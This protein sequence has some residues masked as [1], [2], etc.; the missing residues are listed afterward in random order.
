MGAL[1]FDQNTPPQIIDFDP[2]I[3][4]SVSQGEEITFWISAID[5]DGD[6]LRYRWYH[7]GEVVGEDSTVTIQFTQTGRDTVIG[8]VLDGWGG[9]VDSVVWDDIAV[10]VTVMPN[11]PIPKDLSLGQAYPNPFNATTVIPFRVANNGLVTITVF[12]IL[13]R[14]VAEL[15]N[16]QAL[17]GEYRLQWSAEDLPS[18]IYFVGLSAGAENHVRKVVLLK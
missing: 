6:S 5:A 15:F 17:P 1:Y 13:G 3:L 4:T 14:E 7:Y 18:G 12:D 2:D 8:K 9:G 16:Q 10:P 11:V